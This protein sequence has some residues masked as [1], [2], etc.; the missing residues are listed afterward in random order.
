[1]KRLHATIY[2]ALFALGTVVCGPTM[3]ADNLA[4]LN[5]MQE[6]AVTYVSGGIGD[7]E[8]QKMDGLAAEYPLK[9]VFATKGTP[10]EFLS[11]IKVQVKDGGGK[12]LVDAVSQGPFFLLKMPAGKYTINADNDGVAKQQVVQVVG[13]KPQRVVFVW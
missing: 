12:T 11:D 4:A 10:N 5:P 8:R 6:G 9:L 1:M 13:G 7:D 3:A 2:P